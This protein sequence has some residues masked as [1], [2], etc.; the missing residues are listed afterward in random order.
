VSVRG[1]R[2]SRTLDLRLGSSTDQLTEPCRICATVSIERMTAVKSPM[3]A[4]LYWRQSRV[5]RIFAVIIVAA[6]FTNMYQMTEA[7]LDESATCACRR[8]AR[9][10]RCE[11]QHGTHALVVSVSAQPV[12]DR[13]SIHLLPAV[14]PT[15]MLTYRNIARLLHMS[16]VILAPLALLV[17]ITVGWLELQ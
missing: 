4:R 11:F 3:H 2:G 1:D 14:S 5:L 10:W 15:L 13:G 16:T 17:A 7:S 8:T 9:E 12:D 6:C